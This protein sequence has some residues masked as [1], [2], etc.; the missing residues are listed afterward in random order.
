MKYPN[1]PTGL[2]Y[3]LRV[4]PVESLL[5]NPTRQSCRPVSYSH[6]SPTETVAATKNKSQKGPGP[7]AAPPLASRGVLVTL[8][9]RSPHG[10]QGGGRVAASWC[11]C[12]GTPRRPLVS[13]PRLQRVV[14][15][16]FW[17]HGE[18]CVSLTSIHVHPASV[19][20]SRP[21]GW[22]RSSCGLPSAPHIHS[23]FLYT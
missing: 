5:A 10:E 20:S 15:R 2:P 3:P 23:Q 14:L 16:V 6:V 7:L 4:P 9:S 8:M 1:S 19:Q 12:G 21:M 22:D 17:P 18:C 11:S 13:W